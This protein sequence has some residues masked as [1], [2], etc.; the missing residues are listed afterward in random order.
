MNVDNFDFAKPKLFFKNIGRYAATSTYI[1]IRIPFNFTMLFDTKQAIAEVYSKLLVQHDEP[2]K[3]ITK[4]ITD[5]SLAITEGSLE[6]FRD[7]IKELPQKSEISMPGRPKCFIAIGISIAAMAMSMFNAVRITQLN[8]EKTDLNL[9]INDVVQVAKKKNL[10]PFVKFALDLFQIE[11][12]HLYTLAMD[13]FTLIHHILMVA[14]SNLLN[15][16]KFSVHIST[17]Y[18]DAISHLIL[19]FEW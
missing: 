9:D 16:Y 6:D 13:E 15:L 7:I 14:N 10:V 3:S 1:H 8:K 18:G 4:S 2:F 11:V 17:K 12:S 5:V 19:V